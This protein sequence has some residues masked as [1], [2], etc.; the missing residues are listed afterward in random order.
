M[1]P[2]ALADEDLD[3]VSFLAVSASL[4]L[5]REAELRTTM[6]RSLADRRA[7]RHRGSVPG[8]FTNIER[9]FDAGVKRIMKDYFGWRGRPPLYWEEVFNR[10]FRVSRDVFLEMYDEVCGRPFWCQQVNTTGRPQSHAL[11]KL[12]GA[13]RVPAYGEPYDRADEYVRLRKSTISIAV[14]KL[15]NFIVNHYAP[16]YLRAPNESELRGILERNAAR[17]MPACIGSID[18]SH[19]QWRACPTALQ[20][21]YQNRKRTRSVFMDTVCDEDTYVCPLNVGAAGSNNDLNELKFSPL[22]HA[23]VAGM[24]P[25]RTM[26]FTFNERTRTMPYYLAD[27]IYPAYPI[28]ATPYP[29]PDSR[30]K[31]TYNRLQQALRKDVERLYAILEIRFN[32]LMRPARFTTVEKLRKAAQAITIRHNIMVRRDRHGYAGLRRVAAAF[33]GEGDTVAAAGTLAA[34]HLPGEDQDA[35]GEALEAAPIADGVN[36]EGT[37]LYSLQ[38]RQQALDR[39]EH[40]MLRDDLAQHMYPRREIFLHPYVG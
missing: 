24:W 14:D 10:R 4:T 6:Q 22:Y 20:G 23:I 1:D 38:A 26:S 7:Q 16:M 34:G 12:V 36:A 39:D 13:F 15:V 19:L 32:V 9:E 8:R 33:T 3:L 21:Q 40:D 25:P 37:L 2:A 35:V 31:R 17:G 30:K 11:Q 5:R 29:R 18:C 28:F 27:G